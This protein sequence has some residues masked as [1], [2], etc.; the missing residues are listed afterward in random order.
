MVLLAFSMPSMFQAVLI[1]Y[2]TTQVFRGTK[3]RPLGVPSTHSSTNMYCIRAVLAGS[4]EV[5]VGTV[6]VGLDQIGREITIC[7]KNFYRIFQI[8]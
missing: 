1:I 6:S 7:M 4:I 2:Y 8:V 5:H 3:G